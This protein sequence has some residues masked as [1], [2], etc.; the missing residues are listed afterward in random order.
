M[1]LSA[2]ITQRCLGKT[3][4]KNFCFQEAKHT[5][6]LDF[7]NLPYYMEPLEN[8]GEFKM[9]ESLAILRH[10][11]RKHDLYGDGTIHGA[12]MVDMLVDRTLELRNMFVSLTYADDFEQRRGQYPEKVLIFCSNT[13]EGNFSEMW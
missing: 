10:L 6:G 13:T 2:E 1:S 12:A 11:G 4:S 7:P 9:T 5:L 3:K 8:G